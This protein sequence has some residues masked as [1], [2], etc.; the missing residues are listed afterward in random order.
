MPAES[1][2]QGER[3]VEGAHLLRQVLELV[4]HDTAPG[5]DELKAQI[6]TWVET[7]KSWDG[8]IDF[9]TIGRYALVELPRSVAREASVNLK[10]YRTLTGT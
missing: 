7:G 8:R 4:K 2:T 6:R 10:A 1:K 5:Y 9:P 3:L